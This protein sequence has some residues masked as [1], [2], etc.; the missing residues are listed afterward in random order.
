M[1]GGQAARAIHPWIGVVL[2]LSFV[3]MGTRFFKQN[4]WTPDDKVWMSHVGD[5]VNNKDCGVSTQTFS[6]PFNLGSMGMVTV[7]V[8]PFPNVLSTEIFPPCASTTICG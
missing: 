2:A 1:G 5:I 4:V 6:P 7:N 8:A 3:Y